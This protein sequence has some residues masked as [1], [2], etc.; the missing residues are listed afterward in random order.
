MIFESLVLFLA[1]GFIAGVMIGSVGVGGVIL[2]PL[3]SY[4]GGI[5]I[6]VAIAAAMFAYLISG[7]VGTWVYAREKSMRWDMTGW[8][9]LGAMPAALAGALALPLFAGWALEL[10]LGALTAGSG[11]HAL[12]KRPATT[13][14]TEVRNKRARVG[15]DAPLPPATATLI[16]GVTGFLSSLTGTGG[17]LTLLPILLWLNVP[18]L[19][20]VGLGVAIQLPI[21]A[22]ATAGNVFTGT[23]QLTLGGVLGVGILFGTWVGAKLAHVAPK[24]AL[25]KLISTL[26]VVVGGLILLKLLMPLFG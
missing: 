13:T 5:D 19:T 2:V 10:C 26:L 16:G 23:L 24:E 6:R 17:P 4:V 21:A 20:T 9:W 3:L 15:G 8:M 25:R 22:L 7:A 18:V 14:A 12:M 1:F 11:C